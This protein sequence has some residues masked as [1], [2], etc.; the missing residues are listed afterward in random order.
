MTNY[1]QGVTSFGVPIIGPGPILTSGKVFWV[2]YTT[3]TDGNGRGDAPTNP[4]KT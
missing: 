1:P 4:F 3:G 2:N